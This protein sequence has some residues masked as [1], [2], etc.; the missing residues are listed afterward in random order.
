MY[1]RTDRFNEL[2]RTEIAKI[3]IREIQEDRKTLIT[4]TKVKTSP[5]LL[6]AKVFISILPDNKSK[7]ILQKLNKKIYFIQQKLNKVI[8]SRRVPKSVFV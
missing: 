7:V 8:S 3:L 2:L 1:H 5:D 4:I 6:E